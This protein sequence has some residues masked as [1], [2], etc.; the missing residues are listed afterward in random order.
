MSELNARLTGMLND[1]ASRGAAS[2]RAATQLRKALAGSPS[3]V[4]RF[5]RA[6]QTG[7]LKRI[8]L[9]S[10]DAAEFAHMTLDGTLRIRESAT[11]GVSD[12]QKM[13]VLRSA[14]GH[15]IAHGLYTDFY[16]DYAAVTYAAANLAQNGGP[17]RDYTKLIGN[18]LASARRNEAVANIGGWN[19]V[20]SQMN[21]DNGGKPLVRS[22]VME[23]MRQAMPESFEQVSPG[24]FE[25]RSGI[26]LTADMRINAGIASNVEAFARDHFDRGSSSLGPGKDVNYLHYYAAGIISYVLSAEMDFNHGEGQS[27]VHINLGQLGLVESML[28]R[29]GLYFNGSSDYF[30]FTNTGGSPLDG[31]KR[32]GTTADQRYS[33]FQSMNLDLAALQKLA[34]SGFLGGAIGGAIA[35][36]LKINDPG[37]QVLASATLTT[38]GQNLAQA[39]TAAEWEVAC[40]PG[41]SSKFWPIFLKSSRP[42]CVAQ[43]R[44]LFLPT[45]PLS[46]SARWASRGRW[47]N[48]A[49]GRFSRACTG[50]PECGVDCRWRQNK[51]VRWAW[52]R[53]D[54]QCGRRL[55]RGPPWRESSE[56]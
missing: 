52:G 29:A 44:E 37:W 42:T 40:H 54:I 22:E 47:E 9:L 4:E 26:T 20:V 34:Q 39:I 51:L 31:F 46:C 50:S 33:P 48:W 36:A 35:S 38:V 8:E 21:A 23:R 53:T 43:R 24:V 30:H 55:C 25:L 11:V 1:L 5:Q 19:A 12:V 49:D 18:Y 45:S 27:G 13:D 3:L 28:E 17:V 10:N 41:C 16:K 7:Q 2:A 56:V 32:R 14:L 6:I 15:E